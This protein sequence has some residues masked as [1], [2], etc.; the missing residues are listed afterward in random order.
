MNDHPMDDELPEQFDAILKQMLDAKPLSKKDIS[1][2]IKADRE[3][4]ATAK[5]AYLT[6]KKNRINSESK[7]KG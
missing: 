3:S 5:S 2:K 6:H 1:A 7:T 4:R